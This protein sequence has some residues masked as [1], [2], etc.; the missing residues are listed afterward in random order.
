MNTIRKRL[1]RMFST[2]A[3]T[4]SIGGPVYRLVR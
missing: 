1:D 2:R 4:F 3:M